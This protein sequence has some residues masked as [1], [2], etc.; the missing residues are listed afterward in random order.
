MKFQNRILI[1]FTVTVFCL[2]IVNNAFLRKDDSDK[3][4][5]FN[6]KDNLLVEERRPSS[7]KSNAK[8]QDADNA[9]ANTKA[10]E[11]YND[12][13]MSI[14][15]INAPVLYSGPPNFDS[16]DTLE[17][18]DLF[19]PS[20]DPKLQDAYPYYDILPPL[21]SF[22]EGRVINPKKTMKN[23]EKISREEDK[24]KIVNQEKEKSPAPVA[25]TLTD[26]E[27]QEKMQQ[28]LSYLK[29]ELFNN[30]D[31]KIKKIRESKQAYDSKW[32]RKQLRITRVLELEDIIAS[33]KNSKK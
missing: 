13:K 24:N 18:V 4:V 2:T 3:Y 8:T 11:G 21:N 19:N 1:I 29:K 16:K 28:E 12:A 20:H 26:T 27:I 9:V 31:S 14:P 23:V 6:S 30:D 5:K 17:P 22:W 25:R 7:Y 33:K 10:K 15:E 32:L